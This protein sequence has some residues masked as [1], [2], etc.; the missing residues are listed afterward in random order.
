[1]RPHFVYSHHVK[2]CSGVTQDL[3]N[4]LKNVDGKPIPDFA[5]LVG[6]FEMTASSMSS[7]HSSATEKLKRKKTD[8]VA[9]RSGS[10]RSRGKRSEEKSEF[11]D[12]FVL[13]KANLLH[14]F[15]VDVA[16]LMK[17]YIPVDA[18]VCYQKKILDIELVASSLES[19]INKKKLKDAC[20]SC[21]EDLFGDDFEDVM[22]K[23][24]SELYELCIDLCKYSKTCEGGG[25]G[26]F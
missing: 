24:L 20:G 13:E 16:N 18:H 14:G 11:C 2:H 19:N 25:F 4:R 23:K 7:K 10:K 22:L 12:D 1:M 17:T 6:K 15:C 21:T 9:S 26:S 3:L 8:M 5:Q